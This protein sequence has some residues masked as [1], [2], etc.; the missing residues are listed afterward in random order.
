MTRFVESLALALTGTGSNQGKVC[1]L[2]I[3]FT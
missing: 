2:Q 1:L 3:E